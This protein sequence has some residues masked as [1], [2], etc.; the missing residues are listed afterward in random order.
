MNEKTVE[1]IAAEHAEWFVSIITPMI[2]STAQTFFE[3]G[4]K[5][6]RE[7]EQK[8]VMKR[9]ITQLPRIGKKLIEPIPNLF[10]LKVK[11]K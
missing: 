9:L 8:E 2:R 1:Q 3:H 7:F 10:P 11:K 4:Y 6:G 5:H